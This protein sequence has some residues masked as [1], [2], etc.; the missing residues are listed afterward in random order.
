MRAYTL[1]KAQEAEC[2]LAP[3]WCIK[4]RHNRIGHKGDARCLETVK[5]FPWHG[6]ETTF[7]LH[8][9]YCGKV[10]FDE[11]G[12]ANVIWKEGL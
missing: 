8:C 3:R 2:R 5:L 11:T 6:N 7:T 10:E 1:T 12:L 4:W 9:A